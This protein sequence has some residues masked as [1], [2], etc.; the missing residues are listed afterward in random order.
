MDVAV[1]VGGTFTDAIA[2]DPDS[3][4]QI[5]KVPTTPDDLSEGFLGGIAR[6]GGSADIRRLLHGTTVVINA[7]LTGRYPTT[8]L[9]TTA[10]FR[11][12]LEIMRA[13]R[14]NLFDL[15]QSKPR[16]LVPRDLRFEVVER[17]GADGTPVTALTDS[18]LERVADEV[19][20]SGVKSVAVCL[21]FSF[22]NPAHEKQVGD[23]LRKRLPDVEVSLSHEVLPV[24]REFE[25]TSTTVVNAL[26]RPLMDAYLAE[27]EQALTREGFSGNFLIMQS[28]GGLATLGEARD[29]P[30][31]TLFSGPS[32]GVVAAEH[33]GRSAG[34]EKVMSL[35]MGGTSCDVSA[36]SHGDPDRVDHFEVAGYPVS[37]ASIDIVTV[38]AGG[39]SIAKVD[40]GGGL[41]VGPDS[42]GAVPGP[43]CY[44]RGG[45]EPTVTDA[46]V[47]LGRYAEDISLGGSMSIDKDLACESVSRVAEPL[48]LSLEAAAHGIIRLVNANMAN[49]LREVSLERGRDPRDYSL[50]A[51]GG[52]G[53]AHVVEV[54]A[55]LGMTSVVVPPFP[56]AASAQGML[57]ADIRRE[58]V[59]TIYARLSAISQEELAALLADLASDTAERLIAESSE[60]PSDAE[61]EVFPAIDLRYLGQTYEITVPCP[62]EAISPEELG[63]RFHQAHKARYGHSFPDHEVEAVNVRAAAVMRLPSAF[64]KE[65]TWAVTPRRKRPVHW[66]G[67]AGTLTTPIVSRAE[68]QEGSDLTHGPLIIEQID[69][70]TVVPP[71]V[72]ITPVA[73]GSLELDLSELAGLDQTL[74]SPAME[75]GN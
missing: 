45:V 65:P 12:V 1:D 64:A 7:I 43:A 25:R 26:A 36:I 8:G 22:A 60:L 16:P 35:D 14:K 58:S 24:Y 11:D 32:G 74:T 49:A 56:G 13:D 59:R 18:E 9:I 38:G 62:R 41:Q 5:G 46:A 71:G 17:M 50:V 47:V 20:G 52:A 29:R 31:T 75:V 6:V 57:L 66:G 51:A 55:E 42:A 61:V 27:A 19:E 69:A 63:G 3:G 34:F 23:A 15:T 44:R 28:N 68:V 2:Y 53:A 39:G 54:A 70:T 21:L 4:W 30:V 37:V 73:G 72:S 48:G 67:A 10:G 33:A 40:S